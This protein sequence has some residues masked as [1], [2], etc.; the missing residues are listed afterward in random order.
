MTETNTGKPVT[1]GGADVVGPELLGAFCDTDGVVEALRRRAASIGLS[2]GLIEQI[3]DMPEGSVGKYLSALRVKALTTESLTRIAAT[4]G[5]RPA[6]VV[7]PELVAAM[8]P[9]W[10]TRD[11]SK[12]LTQKPMC[13]QGA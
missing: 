2:Y 4:M 1:I 6:L 9:Q 3:A 8:Q 7:D 12:S 11:G 10:E 5:L 13:G